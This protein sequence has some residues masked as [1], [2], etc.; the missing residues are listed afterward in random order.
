MRILKALVIVATV[1][2]LAACSPG[3][4]SSASPSPSGV[5]AST[6]VNAEVTEF[7]IN[8]D[9]TTAAAGSVTFH[10]TNRGKLPH[11]FVVIST[12][13]PAASLPTAS[14]K[15]VED[16]LSIVDEKQDIAP[17]TSGD[18]TVELPAGHYDI[19]CNIEGHYMSGM[20]TDF[21]TQ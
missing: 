19:I 3:A 17:G 8:L 5:R 10:I 6:T 21:T 2:V 1:T 14:N 18:L 15:A 13:T 12:D 4:S 7:S 11:E 16:G 20:H 9:K